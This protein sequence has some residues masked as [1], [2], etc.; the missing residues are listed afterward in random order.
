MASSFHSLEALQ[1]QGHRG[2]RALMPENTIPSF[3]SAM[4]AGAHVLELDL[5]LTSDLECVIHHDFAI[6]KNLCTYLDGSSIDSSFLIK[7]LT[8]AEIKQI[9]AGG[10]VN[11][12]FPKQAHVPKTPIPTL[13][14]LFEWIK[15]SSHPQ[16]KNIGFN[17]EIK[18]DPRFPER[19]QTPEMLAEKI[20]SV[21]EKNELSDRT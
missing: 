16:A 9:D 17:L 7:N 2:A 15:K 6:N 1:V 14:E 10:K 11:V 3:E 21:V 19:T 13:Q 8:L 4:L 5:Y 20:I 12:A 18:R